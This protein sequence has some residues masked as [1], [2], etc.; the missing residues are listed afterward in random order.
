M[1]TETIH[2]R[3]SEEEVTGSMIGIEDVTNEDNKVM[4]GY[5]YDEETAELWAS[6]PGLLEA[7]TNLVERDLIKDKEGDHYQE[8]LEAIAKARGV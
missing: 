7:L 3:M 1:K 8:V 6:A 4:L 5:A 2:V